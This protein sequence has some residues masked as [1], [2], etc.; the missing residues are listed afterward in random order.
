MNLRPYQHKMLDDARNELRTHRSV[1]IQS[2]CGSGKGTCTAVIV[3]GALKKK[4]NVLFLVHGRDRVN[5]FSERVTNLG[6]PHGV[7]M[8]GTKRE[9]WHPVQVASSDTVYRMQHKPK[10]EIIAI[11]ECHLAMSKSFREVLDAYPDAKLI[12][13]SATPELGNKKT[14]GVQSGGIFESMVRGPSVTELIKDGFLVGSRVLAPSPPTAL[15]GLKKKKGEFDQEQ[16]AA[17]CDT[18]KVIGDV[19][20][21]WKR[22]SP[23]RKTAAFCFSQKHAWDVAES[24]RAAGINW[25]YVDADTPDGDIH[26]PFTRKF[27][28][29]QMDHGDL[30]GVSSVDTIRIGWDRAVCKTLLILSK[31]TSFPRFRQT[32]GRGS[33]P[34]NGYDYF[35]VLDHTAS[36]YEFTDRGPFFESEVDWALDGEVKCAS[37]KDAAQRVS[38]CKR[39]VAVPDTG[40]PSWFR[41]ELSRDRKYMLCCYGTFPPGPDSCPY[42]GIPLEVQERKIEVEEG[43]LKELTLED[44]ERMEAEIRGTSERKTFYLDLVKLQVAKNYKPGYAFVCFKSRYGH[45]PPKGWKSEVDRIMNGGPVVAPQEDEVFA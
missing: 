34:Y 10:A 1:V 18:S 2:E 15:A 36:L 40:V 38:Q 13:L 44:R 35:L 41:G 9:R 25:A 39:P 26:T 3:Q 31:T 22:H 43:E 14:L 30:V 24:F 21:H 42:C 33:R 4:K 7:L 17:I 16:G 11:D 5:D 23:D 37:E 8:G 27:Y 6:I 45:P 29:H 19:V 12:G 32:L 28:W 20:E